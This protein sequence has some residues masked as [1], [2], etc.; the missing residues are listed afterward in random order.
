MVTLI[1][2]KEKSPYLNKQERVKYMKNTIVITKR[3]SGGITIQ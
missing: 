2:V 1:V 3:H